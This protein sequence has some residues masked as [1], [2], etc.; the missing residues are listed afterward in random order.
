MAFALLAPAAAALARRFGMKRTLF[1]SLI[2]LLVGELLR[3]LSGSSWLFAGTVLIGAAI[4]VDNVLM[5]ALVKESFPE[6]VGFMMGIYTVTMNM[7]AAFASGIAV[8]LADGWGLAG[9]GRFAFGHCW[10]LPVRRC[11]GCCMMRPA[12]SMRRLVCLL[13]SA[14]P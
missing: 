1:F 4:A 13:P 2:V 3:P 6:R 14:S 10:R 12:A 9:K 5:P 8:P 7:S 11:S